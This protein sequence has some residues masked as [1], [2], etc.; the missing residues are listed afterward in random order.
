MG[1]ID[2]WCRQS[3]YRKMFAATTVISCAIYVIM[4]YKGMIPDYFPKML[5]MYHMKIIICSIT[6]G[7]ILS[8]YFTSVI[9]IWDK[10]K[11]FRLLA[12]LYGG[13]IF[14][15]YHLYIGNPP[16]PSSIEHET[17]LIILFGLFVTACGLII[18][19]FCI[20]PCKLFYSDK[21]PIFLLGNPDPALPELNK[22]PAWKLGRKNKKSHDTLY[23]GTK[24]LPSDK[25]SVNQYDN[26]KDE[27]E[28]KDRFRGL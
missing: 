2:W 9:M 26:K 15:S 13:V 16:Y 11:Y 4:Y 20:L 6:A 14:Y 23:Q 19:Y 7:I 21:K 27:E 25:I 17:Y 28:K 8:L 12:V 5:F 10:K 3:Q 1:Y 18:R 24:F 22:K